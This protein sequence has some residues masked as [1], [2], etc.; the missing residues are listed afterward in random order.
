MISA[1]FGNRTASKVL[2]YVAV[3]RD[4]YAQE[5]ADR[6]GVSLNLVQSQLK[7]LERG[8][9]LVSRPRGRMRF[10]SFN[11]RFPLADPLRQLLLRAVD[12]LPD[13]ERGQYFARRRPRASAK[14]LG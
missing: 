12:F 2:L 13:A 14:R 1:L 6:I 8:G 3:N 4:G 5:I 10:F 7:R 9:V 11:P